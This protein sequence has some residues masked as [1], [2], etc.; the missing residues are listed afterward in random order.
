MEEEEKTTTSELIQTH[1][2]GYEVRTVETR[3]ESISSQ[4]T[5]SF[6]EVDDEKNS[7]IQIVSG[8]NDEFTS[9][10]VCLIDIVGFRCQNAEKGVEC[11]TVW[12]NSNQINMNGES[13]VKASWQPL[14]SLLP[15][16]RELISAL[17]TDISSK[18]LPSANKG[19]K[20]KRKFVGRKH[21]NK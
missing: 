14:I 12:K 19:R 18:I 9:Q 13:D 1:E 17:C 3:T 15:Q 8:I 20:P 4:S 11:L 6:P 2:S 7:I 5:H 16:H 21:P 10:Q